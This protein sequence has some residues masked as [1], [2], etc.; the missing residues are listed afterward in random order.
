[1]THDE[2]RALIKRG[3]ERRN[4]MTLEEKRAKWEKDRIYPQGVR[5]FMLIKGDASVI[6]HEFIVESYISK[7]WRILGD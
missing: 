2:I 5:Q 3:N 6:T 7:G 4:A 1:M